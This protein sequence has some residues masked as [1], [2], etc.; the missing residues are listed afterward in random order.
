MQIKTTK[1]DFITS[2]MSRI[3]KCQVWWY[4]IPAFGRLWQ[5]AMRAN[6][7][8]TETISKSKTKKQ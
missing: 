6:L 7:D 1:Y 5:K 4:V 3:Q 2:R 8:Y